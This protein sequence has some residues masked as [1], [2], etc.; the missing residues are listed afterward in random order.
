MNITQ[1][2]LA[3]FSARSLGIFILH[4]FVGTYGTLFLAAFASFSLQE[5]LALL[6]LHVSLRFVHWI[7]T[8]TPYFPIQIAVA[9]YLGWS[10]GR[11]LPHP[12]VTFVWILPLL[13]LIYVVA[14]NSVLI[15][16]WSSVLNEPGIY[17]SRLAYYFVSPCNTYVQ[18]MSRL[19]TVLPF[20]TAVAYSAGARLGQVLE[21]RRSTRTASGELTI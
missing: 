16:E 8:E 1:I 21:R 7:L 6:H 9:F 19:L 12:K 17:R 4:Q 13:V 15:S 14:T 18:C 5:S 11:R 10:V 2:P 3:R 20:Y